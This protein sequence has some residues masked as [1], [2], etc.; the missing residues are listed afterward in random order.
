M[1]QQQ[2]K[3]TSSIEEIKH[4]VKNVEKEIERKKDY[5]GKLLQPNPST[6]TEMQSFPIV[7]VK[8]DE[9]IQLLGIYEYVHDKYGTPRKQLKNLVEK[10]FYE[11]K[12]IDTSGMGSGPNIMCP[13]E[14]HIILATPN[15]ETTHLNS[16]NKLAPNPC[17]KLADH[18]ATT[19]LNSTLPLNSLV[20]ASGQEIEA[21]LKCNTLE[22]ESRFESGNLSKAFQM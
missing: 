21:T 16:T 12:V 20:F 10:G 14:S 18:G 19:S 9:A 5:E 7:K 11:T 17:N 1:P 13:T 2:L 3:V 22:F 8:S 4:S 6:Q 15:L